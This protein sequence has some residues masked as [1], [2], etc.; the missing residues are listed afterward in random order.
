MPIY[1]TALQEPIPYSLHF[2]IAFTPLQKPTAIFS[3]SIRKPI[4]YG[5]YSSIPKPSSNL[6][7]LQ[8]TI[9][10]LLLQKQISIQAYILMGI[11]AIYNRNFKKAINTNTTSYKIYKMYLPML[12]VY[13]RIYIYKF[14]FLT[15]LAPLKLLLKSQFNIRA[16]LKCLYISF[17]PLLLA[18][19]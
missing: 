5:F 17:S 16:I 15:N 10:A 14:K 13:K 1:S 8:P 9:Q 19:P 7:I 18:K 12:Y 2:Y 6:L 11:K 4:P 3:S